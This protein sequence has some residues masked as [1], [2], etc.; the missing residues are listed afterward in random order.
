MSTQTTESRRSLACRRFP[1][2]LAIDSPPPPAMFVYGAAAASSVNGSGSNS[3]NTSSSD[4]AAMM[5]CNSDSDSPIDTVDEYGPPSSLMGHHQ[6]QQRD[7]GRRRV[8]TSSASGNRLTAPIPLL[9]GCGDVWTWSK[10]HRSPEVVLSGPA[11]RTAFFH[12]NWSKGS[13]GVRG[14]KVMN[15]GRYYWEILVTKRIF[16]TRYDI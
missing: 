12:P 2:S 1:R 7:E 3:A 4:G 13:A 11:L 5:Q 14:T 9:H 15:N 16:G 6:Q 8:T 10:Q